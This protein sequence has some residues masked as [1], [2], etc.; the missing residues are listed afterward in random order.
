MAKNNEKGSKSGNVASKGAKPASSPVASPAPAVAAP[1]VPEISEPE[2]EYIDQKGAQLGT[3]TAIPIRLIDATSFKNQRTG[4]FTIGDSSESGVDQSFTELV[5]SIGL[6]GQKDPITVRRKHEGIVDNGMPFEVIKGFRRF[7]AIN[8]LAQRAGTEDTAT[9]NAIVKVL[10]DLQAL[11]ENIFENTA[12]DNLTGPD[13]AWAAYH[14]Q[15]TY[16]ANG[17]PFSGKVVARKLGKNQPHIARLLRIVTSAPIVAKA[18][19]EARS[20]ITLDSLDRISKMD[21]DKQE[22]EYKRVNALL[23]GRNPRGIR[24]DKPPIETAIKQAEKAATFLGSLVSQGLITVDINWEANLGHIGVKTADLTAQD[25]RKV[26]ALAADAFAKAKAPKSA[27]KAAAD[28]Q[29]SETEETISPD[30]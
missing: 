22:E 15:E 4:D 7:A 23:A 12:R 6:S 3:L 9:V 24:G 18:W 17:M 30:N 11:E 2:P 21:P 25:I 8:L 29:A 1:A 26:G 13:L 14:L 5:D 20:P 16:K 19:Q 28:V 27:A 10:T